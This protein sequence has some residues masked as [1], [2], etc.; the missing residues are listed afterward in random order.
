[1]VVSSHLAELDQALHSQVTATKPVHVLDGT[2]HSE[3]FLNGRRN[4]SSPQQHVKD[5]VVDVMV[6]GR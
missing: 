3:A 5:V 2:D 1:M 4:F 6:V